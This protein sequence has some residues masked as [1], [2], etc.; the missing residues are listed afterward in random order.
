MAYRNVKTKE[1]ESPNTSRFGESVNNIEIAQN[2]L[3]DAL[4]SVF[5]SHMGAKK[6][7]HQET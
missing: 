7:G 3:V 4:V 5:I 1:A 6:L 2:E